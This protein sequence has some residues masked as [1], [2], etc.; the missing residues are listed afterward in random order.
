MTCYDWLTC[1]MGGSLLWLLDR[2][3][4]SFYNLLQSVDC[5]CQKGFTKQFSNKEWPR[6]CRF[7][8][9]WWLETSPGQY[10]HVPLSKLRNTIV[11]SSKESGVVQ[12]KSWKRKT[13]NTFG[14]K[15]LLDILL[16]SMVVL[17]VAGSCWMKLNC[18]LSCSSYIPFSVQDTVE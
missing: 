12:Q 15:Q 6:Q 8:L 9:P 14:K 5:H 11:G 13:T 17:D 7:W 18:H 10:H 4:D 2:V 3:L 16:K 1:K